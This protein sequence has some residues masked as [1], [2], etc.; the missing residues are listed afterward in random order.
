MR[1][2]QHRMFYSLQIALFLLSSSSCTSL[3]KDSQQSND[4]PCRI[5]ECGRE[6]DASSGCLILQQWTLIK[7]D[8]LGC[9]RQDLL[10][11]ILLLIGEKYPGEIPRLWQ[12][13]ILN[14]KF[15]DG[16]FV[17]DFPNAGE[18]QLQGI[19]RRDGVATVNIGGNTILLREEQTLASE[20]VVVYHKGNC[21]I[22]PQYWPP[23]TYQIY[24]LKNG[25]ADATL[26][27]VVRPEVGVSS[28]TGSGSHGIMPEFCNNQVILYGLY[29]SG[30]Y[31]MSFDI[32][33]GEQIN[34][35]HFR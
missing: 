13:T 18:H 30:A 16:T 1:L 27:S 9:E 17:F 5:C 2:I 22:I 20:A 10:G 29:S 11:N 19:T 4:L 24:M 33:L 31:V 7:E 8:S 3:H 26:L 14:A 25:E 23:V 6:G 32:T 34:S 28:F 12:D 15:N 35:N 21:F